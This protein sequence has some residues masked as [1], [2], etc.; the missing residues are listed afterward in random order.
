MLTRPMETLK[1]AIP[2]LGFGAMRLPKNKEGKVDFEMTKKLIDDAFL[3]GIRYFDTSTIY[4]DK[5]SEKALKF[6]LSSYKR[7]EYY[8]TDKLTTHLF[9]TKEE[10]W[11]LFDYQLDACGVEFFD[12]YL[13]HALNA[14][15]YEKFKRLDGYDF[16][17]QKQ[18][19]G[20]IKHLGFSFHDSPKVLKRILDDHPWEFC[21]IQFNYLDGEGMQANELY[22]ILE[23]RD[24]PCIVMEPVKGGRLSSFPDDIESIFKN[25]HP[26][27]ST[28]SW[29]IRW[30]ANHPNVKI[31][32]SGMNTLEQLEDN[33]HSINTLQPFNSTENKA[34]EAVVSAIEKRKPV[35]CTGCGYCMDCPNGVDIPDCFEVYSEYKI[36]G[37]NDKFLTRCEKLIKAKASGDFC[38]QCGLCETKCPQQIPIPQKL[39]EM[40]SCYQNLKQK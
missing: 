24:I 15:N 34:I 26:D 8:I 12:F 14:T 22:R 33:T 37:D 27:W 18:K 28:S 17:R 21:Q 32:L 40:V 29:A 38:I 35:S 9:N 20:K 16:L 6:A 39:A 2:L 7:G 31:L 5:E 30:V 19:E 3:K 23:E 4:C 1:E 10:M 25:V 11:D 13:V 36:W